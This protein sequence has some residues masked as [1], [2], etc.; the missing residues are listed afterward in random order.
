MDPCCFDTTPTRVGW[1]VSALDPLRPVAEARYRTRVWV[2]ERW[3]LGEL[4]D[5]V[6]LAVG[7]LCANAVRHGGGLAGLELVLGAGRRF[8]LPSLRVVVVDREPARVPQL[9]V[10]SDP[11][12]ESGRGLRLVEAVSRRWG[13]HRAGCGEKSVWSTFAV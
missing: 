7:E 6:E 1:D 12:V 13:W 3:G 9:T 5:S 10:S 8:A 2:Q 4:A 11:L